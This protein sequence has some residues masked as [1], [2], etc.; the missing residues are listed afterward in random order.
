MRFRLRTL[1]IAL[2]AGP[3]AL[4]GL[5]YLVQHPIG[6]ALVAYAL[7]FLASLWL[8]PPDESHFR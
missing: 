7:W 4:A 1:M 3:P 6:G 5:W 8:V 2:A